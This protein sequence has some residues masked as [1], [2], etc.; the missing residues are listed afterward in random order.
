MDLHK[1]IR[2]KNTPCPSIAS[3]IIIG[4]SVGLK[5]ITGS[6][7][8]SLSNIAGSYAGKELAIYA[9]NNGHEFKDINDVERYFNMLDFANI[10]IN[11][12]GDEIIVKI[13]KCNICPKRICG[14]EFE[15]TACPWGGLLIGF[16]NETLKYNLGYQINLKPAETCIIKL[17]KKQ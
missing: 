3:A 2:T 1:I 14:Y 15:G 10:E 5:L 7:A 9:M 8:Q 16:I 4:Y 13:L 12:E 11:E 17:K 6:G